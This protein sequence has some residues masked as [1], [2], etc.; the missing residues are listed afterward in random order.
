[1]DDVLA[2]EDIFGQNVSG[3]KGKTM[4]TKPVAVSGAVVPLPMGIMEKYQSVTLGFDLMYV[5]KVTF[6]VTF[7]RHIHFGMVERLGS[8]KEEDIVTGLRSIVMLYKSCGLRIDTFLGDGEFEPLR[9]SISDMG[10]QLNVTLHDKHVG[11]VDHYIRMI[12]ER[13][14]ASFHA[15]PFKNSL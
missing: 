13:A 14:R 11:D 1:V 5:N 4:Q 10:G 8:H 7:S 3:L 6:L 12:E 15:T 2:A 9:G